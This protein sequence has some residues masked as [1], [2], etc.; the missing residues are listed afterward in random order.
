MPY[1]LRTFY[2]QIIRENWNRP[3]A[4][5]SALMSLLISTIHKE[6]KTLMDNDIKLATIGSTSKLPKKWLVFIE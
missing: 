1:A 5:V 6:T 3:D 2:L 4:E